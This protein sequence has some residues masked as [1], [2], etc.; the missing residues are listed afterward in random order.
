MVSEGLSDNCKTFVAIATQSETVSTLQKL[1]QALRNFDETENAYWKK[2]ENSNDSIM[3]F[4]NTWAFRGKSVT[5]CK[6]GSVGRRANDSHKPNQRNAAVS[7]NYLHTQISLVGSKTV[8]RP[9][10]WWVEIITHL[11]SNLVMMKNFLLTQTWKSI[12]RL[13]SNNTHCKQ[14]SKLFIYRS[15]IWHSRTLYW[16]RWWKKPNNVALKRGTG[17]VFLQTQNGTVVK[18]TLQL[19]QSSQHP[20]FSKKRVANYRCMLRTLPN[21]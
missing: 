11:P 1:K 17:V 6:F 9:K 8:I 2:P 3:K 5:C 14:R 18:S 12:S 15:N 4:K 21:M 19:N 16:T 13:W 10:R 20:Q 7:V